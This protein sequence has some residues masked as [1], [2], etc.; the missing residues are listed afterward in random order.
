MNKQIE[1]ED[2]DLKQQIIL[3]GRL[4]KDDAAVFFII[5][6]S[7]RTTFEFSQ[8]S[9]TVVWISLVM[10]YKHGNSKNYIFI[11]WHW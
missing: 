11:K 10:D 5:E 7:E 4:N 3:I 8:N 2:P 9:V 1:L 6:K